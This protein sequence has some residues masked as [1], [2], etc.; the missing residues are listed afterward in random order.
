MLKF[1]T[2]LYCVAFAFFI[3]IVLQICELNSRF[4]LLEECMAETV[5][6]SQVTAIFK[7]LL[8]KPMC[9]PN[10]NNKK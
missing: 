3:F 8:N 10:G 9:N 4:N 2:L 5:T 1:K 7:E 6:S